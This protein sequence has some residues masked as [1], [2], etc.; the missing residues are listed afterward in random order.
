LFCFLQNN[1]HIVYRLFISSLMS[2]C[3][4]LYYF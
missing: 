4:F 1:K 2:L 3:F